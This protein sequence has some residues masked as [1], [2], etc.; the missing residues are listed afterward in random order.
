M[1]SVL[2]A[3]TRTVDCHHTRTILRRSIST[4][5]TDLFGCDYPLILPGMSWISTPPLVA[6]VTRA[7]GMGI[8]ATGP[9]S[10]EE[11]RMSIRD[12]RERLNTNTNINNTSQ[13]QPQRSLPFGVGITLLM[14]GAEE[15][16]QVA[17]DEK[18]PIINLS[19]GKPPKS[20]RHELDTYGGKLLVT[21]TNKH[22]AA[23]A[24]AGGAHALMITGLEAA[25]H[26]GDVTSLVLIPSLVEELSKTTTTAIPI[27]AAGGFATGRSLNAALALGAE[28]IAMGTR[29]AVTQESPLAQTMKETIVG[30][31]EYDTI[32]GQN[33]DGIP[34][35][36]L[37][38]PLST[39]LMAS[40][41]L[42]PVV[43]V[44][45]IQA[46]IQMK[47]PLWK[48]IG[49]LLFSGGRSYRDVYTIAQFGTATEAIQAATV[50]GN[51]DEGVQFVGQAQGLIHD[52]PTVDELVQRIVLESDRIHQEQVIKHRN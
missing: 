8:L 25:A 50:H 4:R 2:V 12:I 23:S 45:A 16:L 32:Y 49:G 6:A 30:A 47:I 40:R 51:V 15:K 34:A 35:R 3:T 9:L 46:A 19:L 24:I 7:G 10:E 48:I 17:L 1:I 18:V 52:I 28:G 27:I 29:F 13:K 39:K 26:G 41:P 38:T 11:T 5:I 44:R 36:V 33:F 37:K 42:L 14:P 21:V 20:L 43:F 22:H 31:E